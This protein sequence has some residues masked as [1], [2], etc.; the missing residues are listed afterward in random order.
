MHVVIWKYK[1]M[2]GK[3]R[4]DL[5]DAINGTVPDYE[6]VPGLVRKYYGTSPD[7]GSV[8]EIYLWTSKAVADK[9]FDPEWDG[10]TS[11]RW[12]SAPMIREDYEVPVIVENEKNCAGGS[13]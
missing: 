5:L 12:E 6:N 2:E 3:N 11:R 10:E 8:A 7:C 1:I 13:E 9:F 4:Q